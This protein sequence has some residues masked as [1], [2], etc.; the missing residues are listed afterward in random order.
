[1][2]LICTYVFDAR[3]DLCIF[4]IICYLYTLFY[5]QAAFLCLYLTLLVFLLALFMT[6]L[7]DQ[8]VMHI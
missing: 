7:A 2:R 5:C 8:K 1:M 3:I 4:L 6:F